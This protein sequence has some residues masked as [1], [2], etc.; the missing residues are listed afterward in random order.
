MGCSIC[1]KKFNQPIQLNNHRKEHDVPT[2]LQL[3]SDG[4][5][6]AKEYLDISTEHAS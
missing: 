3:I 6:Q 1:G 2:D 4:D 5:E